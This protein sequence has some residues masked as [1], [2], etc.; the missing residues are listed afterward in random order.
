MPG[1][2]CTHFVLFAEQNWVSAA[3]LS[4]LGLARVQRAPELR[5]KLIQVSLLPKQL[6][7]RTTLRSRISWGHSPKPQR[8]HHLRKYSAQHP[9]ARRPWGTSGLWCLDISYSWPWHTAPLPPLQWRTVSKSTLSGS[10]KTWFTAC[11][12]EEIKLDDPLRVVKCSMK[13][14]NG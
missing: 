1:P 8:L 4:M 3:M 9:A 2:A 11:C 14:C 5:S 12:K 10:K 6:V 13:I 7:C